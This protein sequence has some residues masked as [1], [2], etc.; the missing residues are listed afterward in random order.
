MN[1][2]PSCHCLPSSPRPAS[3]FFPSQSTRKNQGQSF[4]FF[5]FVSKESWTLAMHPRRSLALV[6]LALVAC[7]LVADSSAQPVTHGSAVNHPR[8]PVLPPSSLRVSCKVLL[9]ACVVAQWRAWP[10]ARQA[11]EATCPSHRNDACVWCSDDA[12]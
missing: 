1:P 9:A 5:C 2:T 4:S 12:Q 7:E 10:Q 3:S 11:E 8:P 6:L